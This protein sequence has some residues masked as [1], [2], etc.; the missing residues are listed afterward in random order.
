MMVVKLRSSAPWPRWSEVGVGRGGVEPPTFRFSGTRT[1]RRLPRS[2]AMG[3]G[4]VHSACEMSFADGNS[5]SRPSWPP[6][7]RPTKDGSSPAHRSRCLART[8]KTCGG[9]RPELTDPKSATADEPGGSAS[10]A[11][12]IREAISTSRSSW[13]VRSHLPLGRPAQ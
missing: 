4:G 8:G 13:Q 7:V 11:S 2:T 6:S 5:Q 3:D 1:C 9:A 10:K 12:Q